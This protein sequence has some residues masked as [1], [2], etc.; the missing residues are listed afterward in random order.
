MD[1]ISRR[2]GERICRLASI[3]LAIAVMA[4]SLPV[5][6]QEKEPDVIYVPTPDTA[7]QK[8]MEMADV[9]PGD[10]VIDLGSGDGRIVLAA[11]KKGAYAHGVEIDPERLVEARRNADNT[12]VKDRVS[13]IKGDLFKTDF[14]R[15]NVVMMYLLRSLNLKLRPKLIDELDPGTPVVSHSFNMGEWKPDKQVNVD[16]NDLFLWYVPADVDGVWEWEVDGKQFQ[17]SFR[18]KFQKLGISMQSIEPA[19]KTREAT[20][21]GERISFIAENDDVRYIFSGK[22][23]GDQIS[24]LVQIHGDGKKRVENWDA[25]RK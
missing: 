15:A 23:E 1:N 14:S 22:V 12:T 19:L 2:R 8:M 17:G 13:F 5:T 3:L 4:I 24:G 11:A 21:D 9:G 18:Q 6:A 7:V 25:V 16:G 20:L 10:Y